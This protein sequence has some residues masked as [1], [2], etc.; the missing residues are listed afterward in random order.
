M[1]TWPFSHLE[2]GQD[3][4]FSG[5][6]HLESYAVRSELMHRLRTHAGLL[7]CLLEAEKAESARASCLEDIQV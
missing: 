2:K 3:C 6:L 7:S 1:T 5:Y 4:E